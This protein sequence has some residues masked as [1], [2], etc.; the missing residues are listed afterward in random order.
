M[1][2]PHVCEHS[3]PKGNK[4]SC[5]RYAPRPRIAEEGA[6]TK[7]MAEWSIVKADDW[8]GEWGQKS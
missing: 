7:P 2:T 4:L 3:R 8:C 6:A 5:N 1:T